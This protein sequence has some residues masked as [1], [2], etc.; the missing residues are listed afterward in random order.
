MIK[1]VQVLWYLNKEDLENYCIDFKEYK[2]HKLEGYEIVDVDEDLIYDLCD[3]DPDRLEPLGY[4]KNKKEIENHIS[5]SITN[6]EFDLE[7]GS[8]ELNLKIQKAIDSID[9]SGEDYYISIDGVGNGEGRIASW[10]DSLKKEYNSAS[11][12]NV[13]V[14]AVTG[15]DPYDLPLTGRALS[16]VLADILNLNESSLDNLIPNKGHISVDEWNEILEKVYKKN[17]I[18]LGLNRVV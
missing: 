5:K 9:F 3:R 8:P 12:E 11:K 16:F 6:N 1:K 7:I 4:F 2:S 18:Y 15:Y 13:W 10:F 17:K 14:L